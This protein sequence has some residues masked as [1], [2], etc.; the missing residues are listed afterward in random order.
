MVLAII[1]ATAG[2]DR[3]SSGPV[4]DVHVTVDVGRTLARPPDDAVG[5]T[6][7]Y[8]A[9]FF[10]DSGT[11]A[12]VRESAIHSMVYLSGGAPDLYD[13]RDGSLRTDPDVGRDTLT[14]IYPTPPPGTFDFDRFGSFARDTHRTATVHINY[15]TGTPE[16]A[17]AWVRYA[18]ITH[19]YGV[20][21]WEI[22]EE[23]YLNGA[24]PGAWSWPDAH[25]N[26]D[27]SPEGPD[28]WAHHVVPFI[29]AMRRADPTIRVGIPI[30]P[31]FPGGTARE[32]AFNR[33]ATDWNTT[34]LAVLAPLIDFVDLHWYPQPGETEDAA[35]L[36]APKAIANLRRTLRTQITA[37][38]GHADLLVGE[39]NSSFAHFGKQMVGIVNAMFLVDDMLTWLEQGAR[40]VDWA[41][42][43]AGAPTP[44]IGNTR[45][46][47]DAD[48][49]TIALLSNG[50]CVDTIA[51]R[52][53][54]EPARNSPFAPFYALTLVDG[55]LRPGT[56]LIPARSDSADVVSHAM[57]APDGSVTVIVIN[58]DRVHPH[59]VHIDA[60]GTPADDASTRTLAGNA[61]GLCAGRPDS[62]GDITLAPYSITA[63]T[64]HA[65]R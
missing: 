45:Q 55:A 5:V 15:G 58:A 62:T 9:S 27:G 43:H 63:V 35:L 50:D 47:G 38:G 41:L 22:G 7:P 48:F 51:G 11:L 20:R 46:Y 39:T 36:A 53:I 17:A 25:K 61:T 40:G 16:E 65:A 23:G 28:T 1:T 29:A 64:Y 2:C 56:R 57:A 3:R 19:D 42:W 49:G 14:W 32:V 18:N 21:N 13:Y 31:L 59:R 60:P 10:G 44:D 33:F 4:A 52:H 8:P 26:P 37:A 34:V 12:R 6:D 24:Y 30:A 54:C